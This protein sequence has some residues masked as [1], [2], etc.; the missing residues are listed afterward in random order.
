MARAA[1]LTL[2]VALLVGC[3]DEAGRSA[4]SS[5]L[6]RGVP[7]IELSSGGAVQDSA[8][9]IV[10]FRDAEPIGVVRHGEPYVP[11]SKSSP[12]RETADEVLV[13]HWGFEPQL[14]PIER[15]PG[16]ITLRAISDRA[17]L[18]VPLPAGGAEGIRAS[19]LMHWHRTGSAAGLRLDYRTLGVDEQGRLRIRIPTSCTVLALVDDDSHTCFWPS[20]VTLRPGSTQVIERL[21][22]RPFHV[23]A[24]V[25]GTARQVK[26]IR[27][28]LDFGQALPERTELR[29]ALRRWLVQSPM[30]PH[31]KS[32]H[33]VFPNTTRFRFHF[34]GR[35]GESWLYG[36]A[37]RDLEDAEFEL[38][39]PNLP[40]GTAV[41]VA[42][43]ELPTDAVL[44]PG[45]LG[46]N[47]SAA[48][49]GGGFH[50]EGL[51]AR[52]DEGGRVGTGVVPTADT[53]TLFSPTRGIA[54]VRADAQ[55]GL[56]GT[57]CTGQLTVTQPWPTKAAQGTA[58]V[59]IWQALGGARN[60]IT[61]PPKHALRRD[62]LAGA[63]QLEFVGLPAGEYELLLEY[64]PAAEGGK[65]TRIRRRAKLGAAKV[66]SPG[67][68]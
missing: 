64:R 14:H 31:V 2:A 62:V 54:W 41:T 55:Q 30:L 10:Y 39:V 26:T 35:V 23:R 42:G 59:S 12:S 27:A 1:C 40:L 11:A 38:P 5:H 37:G 18:Q 17:T 20:A 53:Y 22:K 48:V 61:S 47:A 66:E 65:R 6:P 34:F 68:N 49:L 63:E 4:S 16:A 50:A 13:F 29:T 15:E 44:L 60:M 45:R 9:T 25:D 3:G 32:T 36:R 43:S 58:S 7:A 8:L 21:P 57:W 19:C 67:W 33:T 28:F 46:I 24:T 56:R 51:G 52:L